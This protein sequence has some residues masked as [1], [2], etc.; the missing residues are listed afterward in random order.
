MN[1]NWS[2][3]GSWLKAG[4]IA[5]AAG[6]G[7]VVASGVLPPTTTAGAVTALVAL[8]ATAVAHELS[9]P[10]SWPQVPFTGAGAAGMAVQALQEAPQAATAI[11]GIVA[12][13]QQTIAA[14][15]AFLAASAAPA[16]APQ[17]DK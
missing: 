14:V 6:A 4:S 13:H 8:G 11:Q 7:A 2:N 1:I 3:I 12:A 17:M 15:Q 5:T 16:A 10:D 9:Q